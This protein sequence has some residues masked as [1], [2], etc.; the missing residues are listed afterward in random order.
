MNVWTKDK[1]TEPGWY[2]MRKKDAY[3]RGGFF[4]SVVQLRIYARRLC[5][6]NWPIPDN[7]EWS[8]P[9]QSPNERDRCVC[10]EHGCSL[11]PIAICEQCMEIVP[12]RKGDR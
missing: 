12:R 6:M 5:I 11:T 10:P 3:E 8:G 9:I 4:V 1:P 7:V 2:W